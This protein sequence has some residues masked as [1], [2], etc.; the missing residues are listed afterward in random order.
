MRS[1]TV[2]SALAV[3]LMLPALAAC[4]SGEPA[5]V[6]TITQPAGSTSAP[7]SPTP[8]PSP[9]TTPPPPDPEPDPE[10]EPAPGPTFGF[11]D[12]WDNI[13]AD[14]AMGS[15]C[16]PGSSTLPD[17]VWFGFAESWSTASIKFDLA[18]WYSGTVAENK[19]AARGDEVNNDYYLI[20]DN[21]TLR[22]VPVNGNVPAKKAGWEDGVFTLNQVIADPGGSLPTSHPYPVWLYVNDGKVTALVVQYIP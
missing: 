16:A 2:V 8:T 3:A 18:C 12:E 17:G 19:A 15:G 21:P 13:A 11:G 5:Q 4:S 10:P 1:S 9:E 20:N 22:T 7:T 6:I 14:G